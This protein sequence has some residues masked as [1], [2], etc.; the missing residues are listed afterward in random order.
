MTRGKAI[1]KALKSVRKRIAEANEIEYQPRECTHEGECAGTCPACEAEVRYLESQL[2][3]RRKVGKAVVIT[4]LSIGVGVIAGCATKRPSPLMGVIPDP[5]IE[6]G[7][8]TMC[9]STVVD[10]TDSIDVDKYRLE[11]DVIYVPVDKSEKKGK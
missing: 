10:P 7:K 9:D 4:G 1:C 2:N 11:G 5:D 3:L 8:V 6:R